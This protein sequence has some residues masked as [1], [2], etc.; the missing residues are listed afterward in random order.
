MSESAFFAMWCYVRTGPNGGT[1]MTTTN[2]LTRC[3]K[4]IF[5]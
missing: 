5:I 1:I 3:V 2:A 4:L